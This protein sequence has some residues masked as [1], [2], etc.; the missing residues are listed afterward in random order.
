M[1]NVYSAFAIVN[2][3]F[4]SG[5]DGNGNSIDPNRLRT[6]P[7]EIPNQLF[8]ISSA[9]S[10]DTKFYSLFREFSKKMFMGDKRY[11]VA[12][13]TCEIPLHPTIHGKLMNPLFE[14]SIIESELR[15]N[16]DKARREYYCQFTTDAGTDAIIKRS[17]INRNEEVR[18]PLLYNDTG[19]KKFVIAYDPARSRDNSV[20]LVGELYD[21]IQL[22]GSKDKRLRLVNC[23]NLVDVGKKIKSPMQTPEQIEY[24]KK[25]IL[26][27]NGGADA[28]GNIAYILIDAGSG[29]GG[30]NIADYLMPDWTDKAGMTH[31]GLID[32]EYSEE[33]VKKF[34]NAVDKVKLVSP[35]MYKSEMYE[36]LIEL[37]SQDKIS[38]TAPYDNKDYLTT[39]VVDEAK[40]QKRR[41]E[42]A[43]RLRAE[44]VDESEFERRLA[45]ELEQ[46]M[47]TERIKLDWE[48]KMALANMDA[49]K[50]EL[51]NMV[52][53]KRESGKDS[54][55]LTPEKA[56]I[57]HDDRAYTAA[58][59]AY[60][61]MLE[62]RKQ[63]IPKK[64]P[65]KNIMDAIHIRAP[66]KL[67]KYDRK[68]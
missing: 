33:Y 67:T 5:K 54:F 23:I 25:V 14:E 37:T 11:F 17:T 31:R 46:E 18:K 4:K 27:Y 48:D 60:A 22:D 36:A 29:G 39:F 13:V 21:Y 43:D 16:P 64:K 42:I 47:D 57:L 65:S 40:T 35:S 19:D 10:T 30:V 44:K 20:I 52:R 66:R 26:D 68:G 49:L 59:L 24:L 38:F 51:V 50:E 55:E 61:L 28:Y 41:K 62:R 58:L 34:P 12:M 3:S 63:I 53:K 15:T 32:K 9:S 8:Y 56:N 45:E 1:L 2:K 7:K 6:I